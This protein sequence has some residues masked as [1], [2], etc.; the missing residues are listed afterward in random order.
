MTRA[1]TP[2]TDT[3]LS[4]CRSNYKLWNSPMHQSEPQKGIS[5]RK[6]PLHSALRYTHKSHNTGHQTASTP[7]KCSQA[8]QAGPDGGKLQRPQGL[9]SE[10][11]TFCLS[12]VKRQTDLVYKGI[13][14]KKRNWRKD[15]SSIQRLECYFFFPW[16]KAD[17]APFVSFW[18][19]PAAEILLPQLLLG[20]DRLQMLHSKPDSSI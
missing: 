9:T 17:W 11:P 10:L 20:T 19:F 5:Q 13:T 3:C 1:Q 6:I 14:L 4:T 18:Y 16:H 12:K 2:S 7:P 15:I 8:V